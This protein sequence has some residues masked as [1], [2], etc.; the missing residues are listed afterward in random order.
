M[1]PPPDFVQFQTW[2]DG[3]ESHY[4]GNLWSEQNTDVQPDLYANDVYWPHQA[5]QSLVS[6]FIDAYKN[7]KN[8]RQMTPQDGSLA[9]GAAWYRV[10]MPDTAV[11]SS[12]G[13]GKYYDKPDGFTDGLNALYFSMVVNPSI[14]PGYTVVIDAGGEVKTWEYPVTPGLNIMYSDFAVR[15]GAQKIQLKDPSGNVV[16][17]VSGGM[18]VSTSCPTLVYA[19]N[20][21]VLPLVKGDQSK[22]CRTW[23]LDALSSTSS[24]PAPTPTPTSPPAPPPIPTNWASLGNSVTLNM[25][26]FTCNAVTPILDEKKIRSYCQTWVDDAYVQRS[27][28]FFSNN[29]NSLTPS[30]RKIEK[31]EADHVLLMTAVR[32]TIFS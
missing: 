1:N 10:V 30:N 6:S 31:E 23:P 2:N 3:P 19:S 15:P 14:A 13:Q 12:E 21:Q 32:R 22:S 28:V 7:G 11:C 25:C 27:F 20:Y 26:G 8:I 24:S 5:W 29:L 18:C 17:S 16:M 4:I 9:V